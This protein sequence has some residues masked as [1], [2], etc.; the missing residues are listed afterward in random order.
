MNEEQAKP[1]RLEEVIQE[2]IKNIEYSLFLANDFLKM[3]G[4]NT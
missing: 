3:D 2:E 4:I 1:Q